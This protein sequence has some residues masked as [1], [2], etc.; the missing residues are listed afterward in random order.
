LSGGGAGAA[1]LGDQSI[2]GVYD[3][4]PAGTAQ[5]FEFTASATGSSSTVYLYVDDG[6]T[7]ATTVVGIYADAGDIPGQLLGSTTISPPSPAMWAS[8]PLAGVS[9]VSGT[10]YWIAV[11]CPVGG[12]SIGFKDAGGYGLSS[13]SREANLQTLPGSW[14]N[15]WAWPQGPVSAYVTQ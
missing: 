14:S 13:V 1:L 6:N 5:A 8:A 12:G 4:N 10:K 11:L 2:E 7:A 15:P 3:G 9:L